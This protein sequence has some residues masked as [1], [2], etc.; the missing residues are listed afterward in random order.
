[1][2]DF[3]DKT[4][5]N[6]ENTLNGHKIYQMDANNQN[7]RKCLEWLLKM[8]TFSI[9]KPFKICLNWIFWYEN[10]PSGNP[11]TKPS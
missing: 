10:R 1:L 9:P 5:Q 2:P 7:G 6:G 4:Y 11:G 8:P 3:L